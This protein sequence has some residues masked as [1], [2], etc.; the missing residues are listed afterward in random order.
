MANRKASKMLSLVLRHKPEAIS[1]TLNKNGWALVSDL[2]LGMGKHGHSITM[3]ELEEIV[4]SDNKQRFS[5]NADRTKI[6]ANQGHSI[7]V[8]LEL[9]EQQPPDLL[10]HGTAYDFLDRIVREG[11]KRMNRQFVHLSLNKETALKVGRRHG[12]AV[13]LEVNAKQMCVDGFKFY[14]SEN[15]VLLINAVPFKYLRILWDDTI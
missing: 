7:E 1:I 11:L 9:E 6:R 8:D 5:F 3:L 4:A 12:K 10:Y 13:V 2:V 15:G 14:I